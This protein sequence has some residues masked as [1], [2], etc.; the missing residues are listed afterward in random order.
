MNTE[1]AVHPAFRL[2]AQQFIHPTDRRNPFHVLKTHPSPLHRLLAISGICACLLTT[3][4]TPVHARSNH[5]HDRAREAV[6][7]GDILPLPVILERVAKS[8]PGQVLE[9]EL[10]REHGRWIYEV[11]LLQPGGA[12]LKLHIDGNTGTVLKQQSKG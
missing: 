7:A 8:Y 12:V 1:D 5:D 9:V 11:K 2:L 6:Q 10:E 3:P 4:G